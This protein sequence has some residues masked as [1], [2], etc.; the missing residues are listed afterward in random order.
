MSQTLET[1]PS[2]PLSCDL[3]YIFFIPQHHQSLLSVFFF[4]FIVFIPQITQSSTK[5][6]VKYTG[7]FA[8]FRCFYN[9]LSTLNVVEY[10][11]FVLK[12]YVYVI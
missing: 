5:T 1:S 10:H 3:V 6:F 2:Y 8:Y 12:N 9:H 7:D 11:Y 4:I